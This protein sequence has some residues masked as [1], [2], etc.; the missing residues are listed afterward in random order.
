MLRRLRPIDSDTVR[1]NLTDQPAE[2]G[3]PQTRTASPHTRPTAPP[4][5]AE[6]LEQ[7]DAE[8]PAYEPRSPAYTPRA[9][10]MPLPSPTTAES[11][12]ADLNIMPGNDEDEEVTDLDRILGMPEDEGPPPPKTMRPCP[13]TR[14]PR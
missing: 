11:E 10:G 13:K 1:A 3:S 2:A 9:G 7:S 6:E 14:S 8:G 5:A 12:V 4:H